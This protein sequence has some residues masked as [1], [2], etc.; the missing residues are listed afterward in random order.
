MV[1]M[2]SR[3]ARGIVFLVLIVAA[4]TGTAHS[5]SSSTARASFG[6]GNRLYKDGR[7]AEALAAYRSVLA[8]GYAS[9]D[10]YLNLGDAAYKAGELGWA[11][12]YLELAERHA[13]RDPDVRSNLSLLRREALGEDPPIQRSSLL[14]AASSIRD[15][16]STAAAVR[17]AAVLFWIACGSLAASWLA[18]FRDRAK[19][20]RWIALASLLL[21]VAVVPVKWAQES[22]ASDAVTVAQTAAHAEPTQD[23]TVEFRLPPGSP[24]NL[25]RAT[26]EWRE[27]IVSSS[28]RG[29]VPASDVAGFEVPR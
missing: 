16:I 1:R 24:V 12:Y 23:S 2:D 8:S 4:V 20:L 9:A 10:L 7:Y 25:G 28:L 6:E 13:P 22:L 26:A 29:W 27:V 15:L 5:G 3:A 17:I 21:I 14:D 11:I 19:F 18:R